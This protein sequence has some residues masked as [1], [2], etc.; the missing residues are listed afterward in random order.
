MFSS[1][2]ATI[3]SCPF[4]FTIE[5]F[6]ATPP[7]LISSTFSFTRCTYLI[8]Y[9]GRIFYHWSLTFGFSRL[10]LALPTR[11]RTCWSYLTLPTLMS[12][13]WLIFLSAIHSS[14]LQSWRSFYRGIDAPYKGCGIIY[15]P[16][17][18]SPSYDQMESSSRTCRWQHG[19]IAHINFAVFYCQIFVQNN[20][21]VLH[22][23]K[24]R[25]RT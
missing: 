9:D 10:L 17:W 15:E 3:R 5:M 2:W 11:W 24:D 25:R 8:R 14:K 4:P 23:W 13:H 20:C 6:N 22:R 7:I 1:G 19:H 12:V 21:Q 16:V 18:L